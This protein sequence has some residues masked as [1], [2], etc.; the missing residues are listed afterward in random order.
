MPTL[1][2]EILEKANIEAIVKDLDMED[3]L[4]EA[5]VMRIASYQQRAACSYNRHVKQRTFRARDLV[6]RKI[7]ENMVDPTVEKFQPT[8][9]GQ[10]VIVKMGVAGSYTLNKLDGTCNTPKYT[11]VVFGLV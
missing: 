9:E 2:I 6:L 10:Y 5:A 8:W 3:E 11:L 7:F 4:L 1:R